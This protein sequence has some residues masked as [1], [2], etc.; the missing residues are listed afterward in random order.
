MRSD[1]AGAGGAGVEDRGGVAI[2]R[3]FS[4]QLEG[5]AQKGVPSKRKGTR[6]RNTRREVYIRRGTPRRL[7][8]KD[9]VRGAVAAIEGTAYRG[10]SFEIRLRR[11]FVVF[12]I[13]IDARVLLLE[14]ILL[15]VIKLSLSLRL[16]FVL[17][18]EC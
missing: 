15:R 16:E 3:Q 5:V 17:C 4:R 8:Q 11:Y 7:D 18:A 1:P 6:A 10:M 14:Q 12:V 13:S 9:S 2:T